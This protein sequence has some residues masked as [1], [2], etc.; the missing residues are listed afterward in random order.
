M[1]SCV[2]GQ[3]SAWYRGGGCTHQPNA[4]WATL[5]P[6]PSPF[7]FEV[8]GVLSE[9]PAHGTFTGIPP[10]HMNRIFLFPQPL[11]GVMGFHFLF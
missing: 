10:S 4:C 2:C 5:G 8:S 3:H 1:V 9:E 7:A 11:T 6:S